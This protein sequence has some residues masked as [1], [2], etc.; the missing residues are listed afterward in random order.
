MTESA[1]DLS[2]RLRTTLLA[3]DVDYPKTFIYAVGAFIAIAIVSLF[4]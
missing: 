3:E 4:P 1:N 2:R